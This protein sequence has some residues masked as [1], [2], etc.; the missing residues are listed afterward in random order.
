MNG[1]AQ[2]HTIIMMIKIHVTTSLA[3][4]VLTH[5]LEMTTTWILT[6]EY[7]RHS[8]SFSFVSFAAFVVLADLEEEE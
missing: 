5:G 1:V 6:Q 3:L 2:V 8:L 4:N 7:L